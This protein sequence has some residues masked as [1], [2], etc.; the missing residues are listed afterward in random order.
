MYIIHIITNYINQDNLEYFY[1]AVDG[2]PSKA[3]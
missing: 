1:I 2:T 3:K